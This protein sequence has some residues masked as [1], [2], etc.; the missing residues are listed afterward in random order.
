MDENAIHFT[1]SPLNAYVPVIGGIVLLAV[2][3]HGIFLMPHA[4]TTA[5]TCTMFGMMTIAIGVLQLSKL[6]T[7]LVSIYPNHIISK[8]TRIDFHDIASYD[9][10][11]KL[12]LDETTHQLPLQLL[13][14]ADRFKLLKL[15]EERLNIEA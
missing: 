1:T 12:V 7:P 15:L 2:G 11:G 8:S 10:K 6:D 4:T 9:R 14:S 13:G 3:L 5:I